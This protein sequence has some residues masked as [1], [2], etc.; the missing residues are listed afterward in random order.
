MR[1]PRSLCAL[2]RLALVAAAVLAAPAPSGAQVPLPGTAASAPTEDGGE[3][4]PPDPRARLA[5]VSEAVAADLEDARNRLARLEEEVAARVAASQAATPASTAPAS[6]SGTTTGEAPEVPSVADEDPDAPALEAAR[7]LVAEQVQLL[8]T[9]ALLIDQEVAALDSASGQR[10]EKANLEE[11]LED[12]RSTG[13]EEKPPYSYLLVDQLRDELEGLRLRGEGRETAEELAVAARDAAHDQV[14]EAEAERRRLKEALDGLGEDAGGPQRLQAAEAH[15]RA[16]H[17]ARL[18]SERHQLRELELAAEQRGGE[19]HGLQEALVRERIAWIEPKARFRPEDRDARLAQL[20]KAREAI[21]KRRGDSQQRLKT[22]TVAWTKVKARIDGSAEPPAK[23]VEEEKTRHL[24]IRMRQLEVGYMNK[25]LTWLDSREEAWKRRWQLREGAEEEVPPEQMTAWRR[26]AEASLEELTREHRVQSVRLHDLRKE[27]LEVENSLEATAST[28]GDVSWWANQ[29]VQLREKL[30]D[31]SD[32]HLEHVEESRRDHE[33][34]RRVLLERA[35]PV[36]GFDGL[37]LA[38]DALVAGWRFELLSVD[39]RPI[40]IGKVLV[41]L[42]L[43]VLGFFLAG[44]GSAA[45]GRTLRRRFEVEEGV[46]A[47][48]ESVVFYALLCVATLLSLNTAGVPLTIFTFVGGALAIGIGFGSQHLINNFISG[49]FLLLE[50]PIRVGDL[51][52]VGGALGRVVRIGS[53]CTEIRTPNGVEILVP[54]SSFLDSSVVNWTRRDDQV[55]LSVLVGVAYGSDIRQVEALLQQVAAEHPQVLED[56]APVV[57]FQ[58]FGASS[59]DF[60]LQVW[61]RLTR[62][63]NRWKILSDLRFEIDRLFAEASI[64]IPF[65]QRDLHLDAAAPLPVR[66]VAEAGPPGEDEG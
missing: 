37:A 43:L 58:D 31:L 22:L 46:A 53:R 1:R 26:A 65:P 47:S 3:A 30:L 39:D 27:L 19:I 40:T 25:W 13:P 60:E 18:A 59:L 36:L 32:E 12:L 62:K 7:D 45:A 5:S 42:L 52:E 6:A 11:A 66:V 20:G 16:V 15:R 49:L 41:A 14:E 51:V 21:R 29:R 61:M 35:P 56:P 64:E 63:T 10:D 4:A 8:E 34:L 17:Q 9:T 23:L 28:G 24:E 33:K 2:L 55:R 54:N 38:R 48:F 57:L 50:R 44:R